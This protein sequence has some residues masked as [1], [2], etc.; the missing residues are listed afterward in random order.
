MYRLI[1]YHETASKKYGESLE[2]RLETTGLER[3][4]FARDFRAD[5]KKQLA[6]AERP[7]RERRR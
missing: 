5:L 1:R 4:S 3:E 2:E 6:L 7:W